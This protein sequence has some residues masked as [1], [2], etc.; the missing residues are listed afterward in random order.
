MLFYML[1]TQDCGEL[2]KSRRHHALCMALAPVAFVQA[3]DK[4][5]GEV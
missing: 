3:L 1:Q 2:L 4:V 5:L